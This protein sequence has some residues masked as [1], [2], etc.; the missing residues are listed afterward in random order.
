[1]WLDWSRRIGRRDERLTPPSH[2]VEDCA[3]ALPL[4]PVHV[5]HVADEHLGER[6]AAPAPTVVALMDAQWWKRDA[7]QRRISARRYP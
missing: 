1:M 6:R 3:A 2:V 7:W 4:C 5:E